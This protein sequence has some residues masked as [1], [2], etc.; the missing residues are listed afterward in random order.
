MIVA[1]SGVD[2]SG[3]ST[4]IERLLEHLRSH[5]REAAVLWFRPGYSP[6]LDAV[7][8]FLRLCSGS[9]LPPPGPS[10]ER[11]EA[12]S[13][14]WVRLGWVCI[15]T[16]DTLWSYGVKLRFYA[17]GGKFIICDRYVFDGIL[18]LHLR[19]PGLVGLG[20]W[21]ATLLRALTPTPAINVLLHLP[22]EV[23]RERQARKAEPFPDAEHVFLARHSVYTQWTQLPHFISIDA[24][25]PVAEIHGEIL[26]LV[27]EAVS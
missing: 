26:S 2:C 3:K 25:R 8:R 15:A 5:G 7:R 14:G 24:E 9:A 13:R 18:D 23:A 17:L 22:V 10:K 4:Q 21:I 19:F 20:G 6:E 16:L 12:F 27:D 1:I 11:E